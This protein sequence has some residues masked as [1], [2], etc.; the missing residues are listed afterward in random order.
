MKAGASKASVAVNTVTVGSN[1]T[2]SAIPHQGLK[3]EGRRIKA[4]CAILTAILIWDWEGGRGRTADRTRTAEESAK[5]A[6]LFR[7][8]PK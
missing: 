7:T 3:D 6:S 1:P 4:E 8:F 2:L 5:S